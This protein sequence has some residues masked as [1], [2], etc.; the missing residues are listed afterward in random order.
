MRLPFRRL[1]RHVTC[2]QLT[3]K[4]S[5]VRER[6]MVKLCCTNHYRA[7]GGAQLQSKQNAAA[8]WAT[9]PHA[10]HGFIW[11]KE[12]VLRGK[13][14]V[15]S[16]VIRSYQF[17]L[18]LVS[19]C[20]EWIFLPFH[21]G[22]MAKTENHVSVTMRLHHASPSSASIISLATCSNKLSNFTLHFGRLSHRRLSLKC[23]L[24]CVD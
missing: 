7:P 3:R 23:H 19:M 2:T 14:N 13:N 4:A 20:F 6:L 12:S 10:T 11:P 8:R 22:T 18:Q 16:P 24:A 5:R 21:V 9:S 15:Y 17:M 1:H